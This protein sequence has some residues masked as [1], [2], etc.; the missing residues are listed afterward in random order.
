MALIPTF[1]D[2]D[3]LGSVRLNSLNPVISKVNE[4]NDRLGKSL[5]AVSHIDQQHPTGW[6]FVEDG[7]SEGKGKGLLQYFSILDEDNNYQYVRQLHFPSGVSGKYDAREWHSADGHW[8]VWEDLHSGGFRVEPNPPVNGVNIF[9]STSEALAKK[10]RDDYM[11]ANPNDFDKYKL[12]SLLLVIVSWPDP[13]DAT[14][15]VVVY[16]N[17]LHNEWLDTFGH[18]TS[19]I[20]FSSHAISELKDGSR[21][22]TLENTVVTAIECYGSDTDVDLCEGLIENN[23]I[24]LSK[25]RNSSNKYLRLNK[26][27][28]NHPVEIQIRP[29]WHGTFE[30]LAEAV[31]KID[32]SDLIDKETSFIVSSELS[33]RGRIYYWDATAKDFL[34]LHTEGSISAEVDG[35]S[36]PVDKIKAGDNVTLTVESDGVIKINATSTAVEPGIKIKSLGQTKLVENLNIPSSFG[37]FNDANKEFVFPTTRI[38][39]SRGTDRGEFTELSEGKGILITKDATNSGRYQISSTAEQILAS[40]DGGTSTVNLKQLN[41]ENKFATLNSSTGILTLPATLATNNDGSNLGQIKN[42]KAGDNVTFS[43]GSGS[44]DGVLTIESTSGGGSVDVAVNSGSPVSLSKIVFHD[45]FN[46]D[47]KV[48]ANG[49]FSLN[50][51]KPIPVTIS[52]ATESPIVNSI[53]VVHDA[54][55]PSSVTTGGNLFIRIPQAGSGGGGSGT[56][57]A[58]TPSS[59]GGAYADINKISIVGD[60]DLSS[61]ASGELFVNV[62]AYVLESETLDKLNTDFPAKEYD[63][64]FGVTT[65]N[66]YFYWSDGAVWRHWGYHCMGEQVQ[67]L[68]LR[69][70]EQFTTGTTYSDEASKNLSYQHI[71]REIA[72][73]TIESGGLGVPFVEEGILQSIYKADLRWVQIFYG[74]ETGNMWSRFYDQSNHW[75]HWKLV[76]GVEE[77]HYA[78][79]T[80]FNDQSVN[81]YHTGTKPIPYQVVQ[82]PSENIKMEDGMPIVMNKG[83]YDVTYC[84]HLS[85]DTVWPGAVSHFKIEAKRGDEHPIAPA[86]TGSVT[87]STTGKNKGKYPAIVAT[88]K[89][90][91]MLVG[92]KTKLY[93]TITGDA[94]GIETSTLDP[95]KNFLV[96]EP[97]TSDTKTGINIAKTFH[98]TLGGISFTDGYEMRSV[99]SA[100][101]PLQP[102]VF[103]VIYNKDFSEL[104]PSTPEVV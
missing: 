102:R 98:N 36:V 4:I 67:S 24:K 15:K 19:S 63:A 59:A 91:P 70:P 85:N 79:M 104:P 74:L 72:G 14:K 93:V 64:R 27:A 86:I 90:I 78:V 95:Y 42:I 11:A 68:H 83:V 16:Q 99:P 7:G 5:K 57:K 76:G 47:S 100:D 13:A 33:N 40:K 73:A 53:T 80:T 20:D 34:P 1:N 66:G 52:G 96:I 65:S 9:S 92:Q 60:H 75:H 101:D 23:T 69:F 26:A 103:G 49:V 46:E 39:D 28:V 51:Q 54:L 81:G 89:N 62:K 61:V 41:V 71:P 55:E 37:S 97:S 32:P 3:T 38:V 29:T 12:D 82:D 44:D 18:F 17:Y 22:S 84:I 30:T 10:A 2:G 35:N 87:A 8:T 94:S 48:D 56:I 88:F 25:L 43:M 58:K 21:V 77:G 45:K 31:S 50:A 6:Y